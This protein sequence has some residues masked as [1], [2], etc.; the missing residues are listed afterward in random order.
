MNVIHELCQFRYIHLCWLW[1]RM[2]SNED[3]VEAELSS[4]NSNGSSEWSKVVVPKNTLRKL[5]APWKKSLIIKVLGKF[6]SY[7]MLREKIKT[8]W[9]LRDELE[10]IDL[11]NHYYL[12]QF[13]NKEHYNHVLTGGPWSILGHDLTV[14]KW[15]LKFRASEAHIESTNVWIRFP[16]IPIEYFN[17]EILTKMGNT[18]GK[19]TR[20]DHHTPKNHCETVLL[21]FRSK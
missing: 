3:I 9:K 11:G 18:I 14:Q 19:V 1:W 7:S 13:T 20:I 2:D 12:F 6:V 17:I 8:L 10:P 15:K 16:E 4:E 21:V 5:W